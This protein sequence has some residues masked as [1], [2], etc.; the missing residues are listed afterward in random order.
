[1]TRALIPLR[2]VF[3]PGSSMTVSALPGLDPQVHAVAKG[4]QI[5]NSRQSPEPAGADLATAPA[6]HLHDAPLQRA[7]QLIR[8]ALDQHPARVA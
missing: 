5:F 7:A 2:P 8:A 1:M 3:Q 4:A 6:P